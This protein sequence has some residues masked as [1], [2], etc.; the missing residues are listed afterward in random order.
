MVSLGCFWPSTHLLSSD[1]S[2]LI[3]N[4]KHTLLSK[5]YKQRNHPII[6]S[7]CYK[8]AEVKTMDSKTVKT[9]T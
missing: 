8:H 9:P 4:Y 5:K 3:S 1:P 7:S 2:S 6:K